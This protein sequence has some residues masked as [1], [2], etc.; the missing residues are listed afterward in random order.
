MTKR[1]RVSQMIKYKQKKARAA[2]DRSFV[3]YE[4]PNAII[5]QQ[6]RKV[7]ANIKF[8]SEAH[9]NRTIIIT[10]PGF[11]EGKSTVTVN[12]GISLAQQG[13]NV[14]LIDADL[15][16][17]SMHATFELEETL[18]LTS[19]LSGKCT[20]DGAVNHS[21]IRMLDVLT[22]G[23]VSSNPSKSLGSKAMKKL[24]DTVL[25]IYDVILIDTPP[26]LEVTDAS[27]L[28]K[29][30]DGVILVAKKDKTKADRINET[31]R[32]LEISGAR[33]IGSIL[34]NMGRIS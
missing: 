34:N 15:R 2:R 9:E 31:K 23:P 5:S 1:L 4:H 3:A 8:L 29:E 12:L 13:A 26:I 10:S 32:L 22:S 7:C 27:I 11:G 28:V 21:K 20:F 17:P 25:S 18:G 6:F 33:L 24:M 14:L 19:I 30:C 16:K